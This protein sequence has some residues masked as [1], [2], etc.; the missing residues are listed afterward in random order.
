MAHLNIQNSKSGTFQKYEISESE[1]D[2]ITKAKE[3]LSTHLNFEVIYDQ[4]IEAY[5]GYRNKVNYWRLR[6]AS[7]P[8][9]YILNHEIRSSLNRLTF[10]LLNLSKLYLDRHFNEQKG[11]CF[12]F[13]ILGDEDCVNP[14]KEQREKIYNE[15]ILYVVG[16]KLRNRSQHGSLPITSFTYGISSDN[17]YSKKVNFDINYN[18][19]NLVNLKV[20]K[21]R[22]QMNTSLNLTSILNGYVFAISEMHTLARE[23]TRA[24]IT[25]SRN[26]IN[27]IVK[28]KPAAIQYHNYV[29]YIDFE[30]GK[31]LYTDLDWFELSDHLL[32]KHRQAID[33]SEFNFI[34]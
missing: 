23:L 9:S 22:I 11:T 33:Y 25:E 18:Y 10:N 7:M 29:S 3:I 14:T 17:N 12:T 15:N 30:D 31:R 6:V 24:K 21:K 20:P 13:E 8:S 19:D 16:C 27:D 5:W 32:R 2:K 26:C 28:S 34:E 4:V 1:I